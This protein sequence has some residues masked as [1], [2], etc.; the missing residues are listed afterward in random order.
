MREPGRRA[1]SEHCTQRMARGRLP[2]HD[3]GDDRRPAVRLEPAG[4]P[5]CRQPHPVRRLRHHDRGRRRVDDQGPDGVQRDVAGIALSARAD[6]ALRPGPTGHLRR[7]HRAE[8]RNLPQADGR[9]RRPQS[10]ACPRGHREG[11]LQI[12]D[13]A[14]RGV[15]QRQRPHRA[16]QQG[17]GDSRKRE[18]RGHIGAP[19]GFQSRALHHGRQLEPD[20]RRRRRGPAHVSREGQA[21]RPQAAR[22]D[23]SAG[24]GGHRPRVDA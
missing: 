7:A 19:A 17:R 22:P 12:A 11:L 24:G 9:V 15:A 14:D 13:R 5:L 6:G 23:S 16:V 4:D 3:A 20:L 8:I 2:V 21:A 18:L 10:Q 1:E